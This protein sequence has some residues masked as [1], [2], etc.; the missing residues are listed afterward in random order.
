MTGE[1]IVG[2]GTTAQLCAML[3]GIAERKQPE[4]RRRIS[5]SKHIDDWRW[6]FKNY[7]EKGYATMFSEDTPYLAAFNYRLHGF[8]DPPTDHYTRPF[9]IETDK[10]IKEHCINSRKSVDISLKYLLS[11][12]RS[13]K[14]IP[15]FAFSSHGVI[16]HHDINTVGYADD[17]LK[18]F[19]K[20]LRKNPS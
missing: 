17:D 1:T 3:T 18:D 9:W 14:D 10:I 11:F 7:K 8:K 20:C 5:S 6:I 12:L 19:Y 4:A 2:D 15:K 16:S 13:Y